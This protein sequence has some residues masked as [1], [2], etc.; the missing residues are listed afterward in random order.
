MLDALHTN[1][2]T[3]REIVN[4]TGA[5]YLLPVK[6][7][8]EGLKNRVEQAFSSRSPP[9]LQ[10][11]TQAAQNPL[12]PA[13]PDAF[14]PYALA[15]AA[16]PCVTAVSEE[17]NRGRHEKRSLRC[18][19]TTPESLCC[20]TAQ[21]AVEITREVDFLR[22]KCAAES[23][24]IS[25]P[26]S[27]LHIHE[28]WNPSLQATMR[29]PLLRFLNQ[30]LIRV[31]FAI[32]LLLARPASGAVWQFAVPVG[33]QGAVAYL[34]I[35]PQM[36]RVRGALIALD[37]LTEKPLF[38]DARI[39]D[40]AAA[41]GLA[42]IWICA[43]TDGSRPFDKGY[44]P[45]TGDDALLD[46]ILK[47]L[48]KK[49]GYA[50]IAFI[51]LLPIGH[52]A[53]VPFAVDFAYRH[54]ER[55]I[56]VL[57]FKSVL[58]P[59]PKDAG[60]GIEGVPML[61]VKGQ[62]EE[63]AKPPPAL[64][65]R[66]ASWRAERNAA[67]ALRKRGD[68]SLVGFLLD[69]GGGHF[70]CDDE[71][72]KMIAMFIGKAAHARLSE[73]GCSVSSASRDSSS[74]LTDNSVEAHPLPLKPLAPNEGW[75]TDLSTAIEAEAPVI[76]PYAGFPGERAK[77]FWYF[78]R[79]LAES[80]R[81]Y[82]AKQRGKQPQFVTF[83]NPD[84]PDVGILRPLAERGT[85]ELTFHPFPDGRSF[86]L[87]GGFFDKVPAGLIGQGE[88]AS[89]AK[90]PVRI[91][92]VRGPAVILEPNIFRIYFNR[93]GFSWRGAD[94]W[95]VA[96]HAGDSLHRRAVQVGHMAIPQR[97]TDGPPQRIKFP[98]I[99]DQPWTTEMVALDASVDSRE[100]PE[101]CVLS[102]PAAVSAEVLRL[103]EVPAAATYP[104]EVSVL[105]YQWG[106][107]F[108]GP[109]QSAEPIVRTFHIVKPAPAAFVH[110]GLLHSREELDFIATKVKSGEEPWK[111]AW[112]ALR[113]S[114]YAAL[115]WKPK[116]TADV[117][118]DPKVGWH[119]ARELGDDAIAV[120]THALE[121]EITGDRAHAQ[122]AAEILNAWSHSL[123]SITGHDAQLLGGI[124]GY[125]LCN[126]AEILRHTGAEWPEAEQEQFRKMLTG[127]FY[128]LI[129]DFFPKAN[130]NWDA[131]MIVTTMSIGVFCDDRAIYDRGVEHLLHSDSNGAIDH[132][133]F[134][135]GQC[136]ESARDQQ[137][138]QLGLAFLADACE[139]GWKQGQDFWGAY[140]NRVATGFEYTAKYNLGLDVPVDGKISPLG[141][142]NF[143]PA[144]EKVYHHYHDRRGLEMQFTKRV[145]ERIR[146]EGAQWDHIPW[147]TLMFADLPVKPAAASQPE[148][149]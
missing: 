122:K 97:N 112:A 130:G 12:R 61:I 52:S 137:H 75:L 64:T 5:D 27:R 62:F 88:S 141:R 138:T 39:R 15:L 113:K 136:Q 120:Y 71:M 148:A 128:P 77:A 57:D 110:P 16:A 126:A 145:I 146:P 84:V 48:A 105:A 63:W 107:T 53:G 91:A 131:S 4:G 37:N 50:E 87:S 18:I 28:P 66:E 80:V 98:K 143:R 24:V 30:F 54:P 13:L 103:T 25:I 38:E 149:H 10:K 45:E 124:V 3:L 26:Q 11:E 67:L 81:N 100:R 14:S 40:A 115:N 70:D 19:S 20:V 85:V 109:R 1:Q 36:E 96:Y 41:E 142:G 56:A 42:I 76:A 59:R 68:A 29:L 132:Y 58:P 90:G 92:L 123:K 116:P 111:S 147:G 65:D 104:I 7:N 93:S 135:S 119:G 106:R 125:K 23:K 21:S 8:H 78:D 108:L 22:G 72:T 144:Y 73:Q 49:S 74:H 44:K 99:P 133:I 2:Q 46:G 9:P 60:A 86:T 121:W 51:P 79:E 140:D 127:I 55:T 118:R 32:G 117:L 114:P 134:A 129:H 94:L 6:D 33:D 95:F 34:Y 83:A 35:P 43:N 17:R 31:C 89:H 47:D 69:A 102:G 139:T 82:G 101:Y